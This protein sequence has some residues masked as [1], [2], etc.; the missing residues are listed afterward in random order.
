MYYVYVWFFFFGFFFAIGMCRSVV[1]GWQI[2][3]EEINNHCSSV[4]FHHL[5]NLKV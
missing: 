3:K 4:K 5:L 1:A 2:K